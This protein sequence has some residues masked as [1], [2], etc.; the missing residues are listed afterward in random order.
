MLILK[1]MLTKT[2]LLRRIHSA[3]KRAN[4]DASKIRLIAATKNVSV[5]KIQ[6]AVSFGLTEIG[7]N[8]VQSAEEKY[9]Q[10]Q[11]MPIIMH[12]I[13][14]LQTNKVKK[15]I[16][17]FSSIQSVDSA[18]L[19]EVISKRASEA[20]KNMEVYIEV[21][22]SSEASK[23]GIIPEKTVELAEQ[24]SK[25]P[26]LSLV[27]L[28]TIGPLTDDEVA[29][30]KSFRLLKALKGEI[31]S[32]KLPNVEMKYLSMGMTDDFEIAIEEGSDIVRIGRAIF[33]ERPQTR[34]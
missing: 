28:M 27:G 29:I 16:Q 17:M 5:Q 20:K 7:E 21:N 30:R 15:A 26:N 33:G 8:R 4:R 9:E 34:D 31:L 3:A 25:L 6:E 19:A 32:K 18:H 24:I 12:M 14:H 23:Y 10:L 1:Y 2:V 11:T 22:T 13:G